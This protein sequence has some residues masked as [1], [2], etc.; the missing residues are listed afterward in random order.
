MRRFIRIFLQVLSFSF[1][2]ALGLIL[3]G[4][5]DCDWV[6]INSS[7]E[8]IN[9]LELTADQSYQLLIDGWQNS[10]QCTLMG[11]FQM[12]VGPGGMFIGT[13]VL[14]LALGTFCLMILRRILF[15]A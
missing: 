6:M 8:V 15:R 10:N 4:S 2:S 13:L 9:G 5:I 7:D 14:M 3:V 11:D 12:R 1:G